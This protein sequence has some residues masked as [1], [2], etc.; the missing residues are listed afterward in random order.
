MVNEEKHN[1]LVSDHVE[2]CTA[3]YENIPTVENQSVDYEYKTSKSPRRNKTKK[4]HTESVSIPTESD[5]QPDHQPDLEFSLDS[6]M[7]GKQ[8]ITGYAQVLA[9]GF[10]ALEQFGGTL[11]LTQNLQDSPQPFSQSSPFSHLSNCIVRRFYTFGSGN[12][13]KRFQRSSRR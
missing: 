3:D 10:V 6:T 8:L 1:Y 5:H 12:A 9:S 2:I 13:S 7:L 11:R 4:Y